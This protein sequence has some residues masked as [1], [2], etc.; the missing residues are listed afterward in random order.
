[1]KDAERIVQNDIYYN[2]SMLISE[3]SQSPD[4]M[5]ELLPVLIQDD[6]R[7]PVED[8]QTDSMRTD[9][10]DIFDID[11]NELDE[12]DMNECREIADYFGIE[13]H[14]NEALEHWIVSDWLAD[15][16]EERGEMVIRDFK[17]LTIW[18]RTTSGQ[19]ISLDYVIQKISSS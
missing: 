13:P 11:M 5:D 2:V 3:L 16:L 6:Y 15:K 18:G 10:L 1:M 12:Y 17:G 7:T 9:V 8:E 19:H 14:T 4:Y